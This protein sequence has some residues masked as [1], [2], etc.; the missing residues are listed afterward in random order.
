MELLGCV[1]LYIIKIY[2]LAYILCVCRPV[3]PPVPRLVI[4]L[5]KCIQFEAHYFTSEVQ[6]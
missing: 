3:P 4:T 5:E 1:K 6:R 2:S